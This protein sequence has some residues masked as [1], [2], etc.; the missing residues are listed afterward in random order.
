SHVIAEGLGL[1]ATS[2]IG[3]S[4]N[5][6]DIQVESLLAKAGTDIYI[7]EFD[8]IGINTLTAGGSAVITAN[9]S[10]T[11]GSV[12]TGG[13]FSFTT[14][15]GAIMVLSGT[16]NSTGGSVF[17]V[18]DNGSIIALGP[19]PH[20]NAANGIQLEASGVIGS[21]AVPFS[22]SVSGGNLVLTI[23]GEIGGISGAFIGP[24][25]TILIVTNTPPGSIYFNGMVSWPPF[26]QLTTWNE[27]CDLLVVRFILPMLNQMATMQIS[28]V[29]PMGA[30]LYNPVTE[31]DVSAFN[32]ITLG[33]G[34]YEF[35]NG[36]LDIIG[37]EGLQEQI[38]K[39]QPPKVK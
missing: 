28:H 12:T 19:G 1:I 3:T 33:E 27:L 17:M 35:L 31:T 18:T 34:A 37:H 38:K 26:A 25:S 14:S 7:D 15:T 23:Y 4:D 20:V 30:Y 36:V 11:L 21:L 13:N 2:G 9:G 6:L 16:L 29:E 32:E 5:P 22:I 10:S 24:T 8:G 39:K